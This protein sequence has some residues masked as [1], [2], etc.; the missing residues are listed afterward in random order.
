MFEK[1]TGNHFRNKEN[2]LKISAVFFNTEN[3]PK[4]T[5]RTLGSFPFFFFLI[6]QNQ[7]VFQAFFIVFLRNVFNSSMLSPKSFKITLKITSNF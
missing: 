3:L 1:H 6:S 7:P 4:K 5:S 2:F